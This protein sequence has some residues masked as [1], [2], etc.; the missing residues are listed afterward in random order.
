MK[1][2]EIRDRIARFLQKTARTVVVPASVGI[3]LSGTACDR[4]SLHRGPADAGRDLVVQTPDAATNASDLADAAIREDLPLVLVP[5]LVVIVEDAAA[6]VAP[7]AGEAQ[8]V[9]ADR[10]ASPPPPDVRPDLLDP[11]PPYL[12]FIPP[13]DARL[14]TVFPQPPYLLPALAP[15]ETPGAPA[16]PMPPEKK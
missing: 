4:H 12:V 15:D 7:D 14:D 5:Y 1:E 3:G 6:D 10:D 16:L 11:P 13:P 8:G 2:K 9:D